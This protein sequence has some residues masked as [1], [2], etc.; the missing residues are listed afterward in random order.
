MEEKGRELEERENGGRLQGDE[1]GRL[2]STEE[3]WGL[4]LGSLWV[5]YCQ[6]K[7]FLIV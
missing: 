3:I 1:A 5:S 6:E 7:L 2:G 4:L